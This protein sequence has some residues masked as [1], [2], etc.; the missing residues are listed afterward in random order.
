MKKILKIKFPEK[1][2]GCELCV[3]EAQRQLGRVGLDESPIRVFRNN[4][5]TLFGDATYVIEMDMGVNELKIKEIQSICPTGVF[6]IEEVE[7]A[8]EELLE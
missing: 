3:F 8:Q 5:N 4:D 6:E 2:I 7:D 1:C